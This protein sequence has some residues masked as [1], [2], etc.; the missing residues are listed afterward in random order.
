MKLCTLY[1]A[2]SNELKDEYD[3]PLG[4]KEFCIAEVDLD[5][6]DDTEQASPFDLEPERGTGERFLLIEAI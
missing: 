2:Y 1:N 4:C 5:N 3:N 6:G